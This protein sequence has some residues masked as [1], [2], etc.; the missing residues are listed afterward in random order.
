METS[1]ER[2]GSDRLTRGIRVTVRPSYLPDLSNP[3]ES[4][5]VF[6]YRIRIA[7]ESDEPVQLLS[8]RWTV[9]DADGGRNEVV[10]DGVVGQ[11]PHLDPGETF[12]Y[13]NWCPLNTPWGTMEGCYVM[14]RADGETFEAAI[15][16]FYLVAEAGA[17]TVA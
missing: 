2:H 17:P 4:Q 15:D 14:A 12:E 1:H 16:R 9:V 3:E 5:F 13:S 10:G 6:G 8:R 11:Q 7:N